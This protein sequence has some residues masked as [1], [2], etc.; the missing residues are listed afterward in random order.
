[1][2]SPLKAIGFPKIDEKE[3]MEDIL[4]ELLSNP[5]KQ[6]A[7]P[8]NS[9]K[10]LAEYL[11]EIAENTYVMA[12]VCVNKSQ[13][14]PNVQVFDCDAYVEAYQNMYVEEVEIEGMEDIEG[15]NQFYVIC[16]EKESSMQ[17]IFWLQNVVEYLEARKKHVIFDQVN[18]V[19]LASEGTIVLPIEKDEEE[20][21]MEK[22]ERDKLRLILQKMKDGDEEAKEILEQEE[23]EL[24]NQLKER[25]KEE[26]F[27]TVM[28]GYFIP[29]TIEDAH[30][31]VLGEIVDIKERK[32][33][34]TDEEM[35]VFT[36]NVNDL[37]FEVVISKRELIGMP[38]IGMRFMGT[39]WLQGKLIFK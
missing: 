16:E 24:D 15:D 22:E 25:L 28:S 3:V 2:E 6:R 26:D 39:C 32:N 36:L 10:I 31:A 7:I 12:R 11:K 30:Y 5:T 19:G 13:K 4:E 38:S 9:K 34:Q 33:I 27:L 14:E 20:E 17:L 35:Y 1:M 21:Q 23:R 18:I 29:V 37:N 8:I